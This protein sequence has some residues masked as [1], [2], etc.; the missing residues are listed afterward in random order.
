MLQFCTAIESLI[1][2]DEAGPKQ[3]LITFPKNKFIRIIIC[4]IIKV[5]Y[6]EV[7]KKTQT[8]SNILTSSEYG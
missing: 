2:S 4:K 6:R 8:S 1:F 7:L 3:Q 5:Q